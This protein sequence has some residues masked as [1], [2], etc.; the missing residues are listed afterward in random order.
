MTTHQVSD[1]DG[2]ELNLAVAIAS[3]RQWIVLDNPY[4]TS[5]AT[6]KL[7]QVFE[8]ANPQGFWTLFSPCKSWDE[9]GPLIVAECIAL[10]PPTSPVHRTGGP[11]AGN[12]IAGCWSATTWH[13]G[14]NGGRSI[15]SHETSA[16]VAAMRCYVASKVGDTIELP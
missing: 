1:L 9:A 4:A 8:D 7:L 12:G 10:S 5:A 14:A 11:N 2:F 13:K 16:L 15:E 6:A 3:G